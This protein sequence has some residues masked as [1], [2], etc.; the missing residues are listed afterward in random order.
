MKDQ[1]DGLQLREKDLKAKVDGLISDFTRAQNENFDLKKQVDTMGNENR[2]LKGKIDFMT[3]KQN[4]L[5]RENTK[6]Y[7]DLQESKV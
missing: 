1:A 4:N 5:E 2:D 7:K 6:L 3:T